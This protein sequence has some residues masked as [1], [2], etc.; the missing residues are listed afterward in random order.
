MGRG[1]AY[2]TT[3][4]NQK[5]KLVAQS[6]EEH[7]EHVRYHRTKTVSDITNLLISLITLFVSLA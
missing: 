2:Q 4:G 5:G 6:L 1:R 7:L 3:L